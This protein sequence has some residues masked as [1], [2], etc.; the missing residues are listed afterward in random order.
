MNL[1]HIALVSTSEENADRFFQTCLGLEKKA[2]KVLPADISEKLFGQKEDFPILYYASDTLS[3]EIFISRRKEKVKNPLGHICL[4]VRNREAFAETCASE[5]L[6]VL[7]V[8]K[9][10]SLLIF[11]KDFDSNAYEIKEAV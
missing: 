9:G 8:P 6:E 4:D 3:F 5:G 7:R 10:N 1:N 11:V 2:S